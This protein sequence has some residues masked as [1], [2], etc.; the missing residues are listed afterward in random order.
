[1]QD[2]PKL[3]RNYSSGAIIWGP[4][5]PTVEEHWYIQAYTSEYFRVWIHHKTRIWLQLLSKPR[6][7]HTPLCQCQRKQ[8]IGAT[9]R[10]G[11]EILCLPYAGF[12]FNFITE[13]TK[14]D[15]KITY[16]SSHILVI[17]NA[18]CTLCRLFES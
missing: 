4:L 18:Q 6:Q 16:K 7:V 17:Y 3:H 8:Y 1:M 2:L 11:W 5:H 14:L 9:I 15:Y 10:I 13:E 12:F